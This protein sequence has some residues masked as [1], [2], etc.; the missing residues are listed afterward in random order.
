MLTN[1][2]NFLEKIKS[3]KVVIGYQLEKNMAQISYLRTSQEEPE[4]ISVTAG[5]EQYKIPLI[6]FKR[7]GIGQWFYGKEA[8]KQNS[9]EGELVENLVECARTGDSVLVD[10]TEFD[11]VALLTLFIKRSLKLVTIKIP[12]DQISAIMFTCGNLDQRMIDILTEVAA[13]L[14]LKKQKVYFQSNQESFYYYMMNQDP[15]LWKHEVLLCDF[16]DEFLKLYCLKCNRNTTPKVV[17]I[18]SEEHPELPFYNFSE[19]SE[20]KSEKMAQLDQYFLEILTKFC[21]SRII[22][23]VFL[24][25]DG[26]REDWME[27]SLRFLCRGRRVFRGNNLYSK[28]ACLGMK[29]RQLH[30]KEDPEY[31]FLGKEKLKANVGMEAVRQGED[32]YLALLDAGENW[33]DARKKCTFLLEDD[34]QFELRVTPLNGKEVK[35]VEI[36]LD[37]LPEIHKE[38]IRLEMEICLE[39]VSTVSVKIEDRGFGEFVPSTGKVWNEE[40]EI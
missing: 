5:V 22:S 40:F 14:N 7:Y 33:F 23:S 30:R 17:Y 27:E 6:L 26:F 9:E 21:E 2:V 4:T 25:G 39:N 31:I 10:E 16:K 35:I 24:I 19:E 15:E 8:L 12:P 28:G 18:E 38:P 29:D 13:G 34:N 36:L 1:K 32:S 11:P 37:G 20:G 3:D